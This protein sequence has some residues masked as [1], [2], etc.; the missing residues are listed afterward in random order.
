MEQ[1]EDLIEEK[2]LEGNQSIL[3]MGAVGSIDVSVHLSNSNAP[4]N[5]ESH[6]ESDF[7][8]VFKLNIWISLSYFLVVFGNRIKKFG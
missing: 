8:T 7:S 3:L 1:D 6:T 4:S 2:M 5:L